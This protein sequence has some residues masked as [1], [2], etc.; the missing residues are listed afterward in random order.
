MEFLLIGESKLKIVA[1]EDEMKE[2]KLEKYSSGDG[3]AGLRRSFW[4]VLD[5]AKGQVG[6]DPGGDKLLIQFY[7]MKPG[8]CEIFVTKLGILPESS[9]RLV[10]RSNRISMISKNKS[11]YSFCGIDELTAALRA[12]KSMAGNTAVAGDVYNLDGRYYLSIEEYGKGGEPM[13]FPCI[14]EFGEG[15]TALLGLYITEH[16]EKLTDGDAVEKFSVL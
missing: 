12:V 15:L 2:Y 1:T 4:R 16:A 11:F 8:G 3:G 7:P 5:M 9:A 14:L 6:F 13:E 10:S